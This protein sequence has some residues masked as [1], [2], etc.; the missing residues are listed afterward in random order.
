[1]QPIFV[2]RSMDN[3]SQIPVYQ[4]VVMR[5]TPL[6][7]SLR[8]VAARSADGGSVLSYKRHSPSHGY[9]RDSPLKEGAKSL[10]FYRNC[11]TN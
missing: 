5:N 11:P 2:E 8:E 3:S 6:P 1:M 4:A 9:R 10:Y 7:P